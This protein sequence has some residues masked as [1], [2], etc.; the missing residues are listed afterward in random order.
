MIQLNVEMFRGM[1][2]RDN[3]ISNDKW[4][5]K[6]QIKEEKQREQKTSK[7]ME[8]CKMGACFPYNEIRQK[9]QHYCLQTSILM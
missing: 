5:E 8:T 9:K 1:Q 2:N 4:T 3:I 6:K 7:E